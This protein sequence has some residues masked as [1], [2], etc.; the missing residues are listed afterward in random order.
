[1]FLILKEVWIYYVL[2]YIFFDSL[3]SINVFV[4]GEKVNNFVFK[5]CSDGSFFF[6]NGIWFFVGDFDI[7]FFEV[8]FDEIIIWYR[9][10]F[11]DDIVEVY[12]YYKG[13]VLNIVI[14]III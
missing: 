3:D 10:L 2:M 11:S 12:S 9:N 6:N 13:N 7:E 4:N 5:G 1:M 8:V 14:F